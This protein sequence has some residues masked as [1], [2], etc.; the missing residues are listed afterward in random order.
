M[1]K[2]KIYCNYYRD[3]YN[4]RN[5]GDNMQAYRY[6]VNVDEKGKLETLEVPELSKSRVEVIIVPLKSD[7]ETDF[8]MSS[9]SSIGFW[10]NDIDDQVWNNA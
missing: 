1:T 5:K 3:Y 9:Q 6:I 7:D 8:L 10:E 4:V 2:K